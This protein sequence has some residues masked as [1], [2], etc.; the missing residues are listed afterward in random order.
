MNLAAEGKHLARSRGAGGG[1]G[2][3]GGEVEGGGGV[4]GQ[5]ACSQTSISKALLQKAA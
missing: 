3:G 2:G 4:G 1:G 5:G